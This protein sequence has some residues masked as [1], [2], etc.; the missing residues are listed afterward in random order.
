MS[1]SAET[2]VALSTPP[3]G[4][5]R[6][7]VRL[8]GPRAVEIGGDVPGAV[9]SRAPRTYTREDLVEIHLPSSP[10]LIDRLVR[11]LLD[12][13]AR[14]AKPGEFTLRAFLNGR[15][16]LAQAE[17]VEQ[18]ISAE[19]EDDRRAALD[20]LAGSFS[21]RLGLIEGELLNLCADAEAAIDFVDQDIEILPV[22]EALLRSKAALEALRA[23]ISE[24]AARKT[25]DRRPT[26]ALHGLPNAGKS[27]LFNALSGSDAIVSDVAGTTRDV[28]SAEIDVGFPVRL[29]DAP[30]QADAVGLDGEAVRHSRDALRR[31]DLVLFVVDGTQVEAS[32]PIEPKGRAAILVLNKA[33]QGRDELAHHRFQ[34]RE[35]VWT[36]AITGEG[37]AE[38]RAKIG[39]FLSQEDRPSAQFRVTLRQGALLK[40]AEAALDRAA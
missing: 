25:S 19:G 27:A 39:R 23:L 3:G 18:L 6:A 8:S 35:A 16:D 33:D 38:L 31:A 40:E 28:L 17:A 29:V 7:V 22:A 9:V 4:G 14:P 12:R 34:L 2:I 24:T 26:V 32:R 36:S 5:L 30:G 15:L 37:L 13:G 21:R 20:Q 10:P 1:D 11:T